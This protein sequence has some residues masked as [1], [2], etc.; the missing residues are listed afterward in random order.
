MQ[1]VQ[2]D[3][4]PSNDVAHWLTAFKQDV[5]RALP[6]IVEAVILFGSRARGDAR[7]GSDYDI[8][9]LLSDHL[10]DDPAIRRRVSDVVWHYQ[11]DDRIIQAVPLNAAAFE[12][13]RTELA[14]RI[15]AEGVPV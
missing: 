4:R 5:V 8:A 1:I 2:F 11:G 9:V 10:A 7:P 6:G 15:A 12:P 3:Q 14:L 13:P